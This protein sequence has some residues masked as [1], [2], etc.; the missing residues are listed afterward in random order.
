MGSPQRV[1]LFTGISGTLGSDFAARYA[2]DYEIVGVYNTRLP[3]VPMASLDATSWEVDAIFGIRADLTSEGAVEDVVERVLARF[4]SVDLLVGAAYQPVRGSIQEAAY[5]DTLEHQFSVNVCVPIRLASVLARQAWM[6][7]VDAN[8]ERGRNIVNLSSTSGHS[9]HVDLSGYGA[10]KAALNHFTLHLA[11][12]LAEIGI[13][14]NA[15][16]PSTFPQLMATEM[17]SDAIVRYDQGDR[18]GDVRVI[19]AGGERLLSELNWGTDD[20]GGSVAP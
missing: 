11:V 19:R 1:C 13:R 20:G 17:V 8:R 14:A 3:S 5:V 7:T 6:H 10:S 9:I 16:A 12:E 18:S 15:I 2:G 4:E